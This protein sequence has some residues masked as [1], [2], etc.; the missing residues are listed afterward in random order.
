ML[1]IVTNDS[2]ND[3]FN[4]LFLCTSEAGIGELPKEYRTVEITEAP[5]EI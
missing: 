4:S 2:I 5:D 3:V 1:N